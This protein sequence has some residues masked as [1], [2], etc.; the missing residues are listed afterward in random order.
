MTIGELLAWALVAPLGSGF[1]GLL[2]LF[3]YFMLFVTGL[4]SYEGA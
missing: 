4:V 3:V 1:L 2:I